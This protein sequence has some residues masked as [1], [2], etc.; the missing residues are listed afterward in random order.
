MDL[1]TTIS[2]YGA[3][4]GSYT[5]NITIVLKSTTPPTLSSSEGIVKNRV[6]QIIVPAGTLE[7]YQTATNWSALADKMVEATEN[8]EAG[9]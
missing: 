7:A 1:L 9:A 3:I 8:T 2:Q 6:D 5:T 4:S